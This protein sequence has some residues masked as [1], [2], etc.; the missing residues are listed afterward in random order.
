MTGH[1]PADELATLLN[2]VEKVP[3]V[4]AVEH[5]LTVHPAVEDILALVPRTGW[6]FSLL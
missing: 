1:V 3:G 5:T 6:R 4:A 2:T